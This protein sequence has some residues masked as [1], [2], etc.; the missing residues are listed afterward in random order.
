MIMANALL[1]FLN[2]QSPDCI[3]DVLAPQWSHPVLARMPEIRRAIVLPLKHGAF[4]LFT[5]YRLGR[6]LRQENYDHAIVLPNSWKSALIPFFARIPKRTGWRGEWRYGVLNDVRILDKKKHS[7]MVQR[8]LLLGSDALIQAHQ[9]FYPQLRIDCSTREIA[10]IKYAISTEKPLLILCPGAQYG[11]SKRWP[12]SYFA[13]VAQYY[14]DKDWQVALLGGKAESDLAHKIQENLTRS[15]VDLTATTLGEAI[16]LLS[17]AHVVVSNDSGLMHV[18][19]ALDRHVIAIYGSSSPDF[20]PPL[21]EKAVV[22]SKFLACKPCFQRE[23][24]L[25]HLHC[26]KMIT[27]WEVIHHIEKFTSLSGGH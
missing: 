17:L 9:K 5:R 24:P 12:E 3:I 27:P 21:S 1:R 13:I 23:C 2:A 10:S 7:L 26:L 19:C 4:H 15:V 22:L 6:S 16:D 11:P 18:A 8:Y 25:Q 14:L 20:T